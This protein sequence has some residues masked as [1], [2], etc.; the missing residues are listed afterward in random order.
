MSRAPGRIVIASRESRL[1]MWQSDHI[2]A[3]LRRLYPGCEVSIL[4]ITTRGDQILDRPLA[5][6]GGKGLFVKELE[7][8]LEDGRADLAVHSAKDV[9]MHLPQGFCLAAITPRED[10]R[11]CIVSNAAG[12][13]EALPAGSVVGT[14]SLRREAQLRERHPALRVKPLRGNLDTRLAK[15]DRGEFRAIVLAAA[16]LKRLGLGARIRTM[17][18]PE[19]SLP[20]P[21]QGALAIECREDRGDLRE[22]LAPLDDPAT[23]ACVRAERAMSRSLSGNCQL[24]LAAY[25][26]ASGARLRLRGLVASPDAARVVRAESTGPIGVPEELGESLAD[27]LRALG[28]DAILASLS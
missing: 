15:L 26:V 16:G 22:Q 9:P 11:D 12:S 27:E 2:A 7:T 17:L 25:A 21:G 10:P 13:L 4:G 23:A 28:A 20:A 5:E 19:Q 14:S 6:V 24:P 1:A 3:E 8:A 18:E